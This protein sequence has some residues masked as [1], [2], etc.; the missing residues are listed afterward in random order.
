M[1]GRRGIWAVSVLGLAS[2][3]GCSWDQTASEP[4]DRTG[5]EDCPAVGDT[6]VLGEIDPYCIVDDDVAVF[7]KRIE[8]PDGRTLIGDSVNGYGFIGD[9][10]VSFDEDHYQGERERCGAPPTTVP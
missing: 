5:I 2:C 8:C 9:Q 7:F 1:R 3:L 10:L 4:P 6:I